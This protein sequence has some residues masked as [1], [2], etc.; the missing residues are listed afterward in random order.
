MFDG[1]NYQDFTDHGG[2]L[3]C[4]AWTCLACHSVVVHEGDE[5]ERE[6]PGRAAWLDGIQS[7]NQERNIVFDL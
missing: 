4:K 3:A 2:K 1:M 5:G 7:R 6:L